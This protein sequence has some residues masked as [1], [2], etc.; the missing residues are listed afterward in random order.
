[1]HLALLA[2]YA[3]G[4]S[5]APMRPSAKPLNF[6]ILLTDDQRYDAAGYLGHP[7][8]KTP[9]L[10]R[11]ATQGVRFPNS[12]VTTPIC[13][14]S[15]ASI[16]TGCFERRHGYTFGTH[17]LGAQLCETSYPSLMRGVGYRTGLIGKFGIAVEKG[18]GAKMFDLL[19]PIGYP[20]LRELPSGEIRHIDQIATDRA[21]EFLQKQP[22]QQPFCL[23]VSFNSPHAEDGSLENLYPWPKTVD[24][25]Y[26]DAAIPTPTPAEE[27]QFQAEPEFLR[28][29]MN[30]IRWYW[31]FDTPNKYVKNVRAYYRM[32]SGVDH[33]IG[34]LTD[35]LERLHLADNTIIV[36]MSDNGYLLGERGFS[37]K[38]VHYEESLRVPLLIVDPRMPA[39]RRGKSAEQLALNIDVAPTL[40]ELA[41]QKVPKECQGRSLA[42]LVRGERPRWRRDFFCEHLFVNPYIPKWEGVRGERYV[43]ARYFEQKPPYEFLHDLKTDPKELTNLAI[44]PKQA[45]VLTRMRRRLEELRSAAGGLQSQD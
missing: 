19:S 25:L 40:L 32:I 22:A 43:Y 20:F 11:L 23:S 24:G 14:A 45:G 17:P 10:D 38:W 16:L 12:F 29:S 31:Q 36:F 34:R 33:E 1:M 30:R 13:A 5:S 2:L 7:F 3:L 21:I 27:K 35:E 37:G 18:Q 4:I 6:L 41:G 28:K 39:S 26:D 9:N 42:P 15:R 44:D 8:L